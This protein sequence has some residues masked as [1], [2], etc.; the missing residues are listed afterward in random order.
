[1]NKIKQKVTYL[2]VVFIQ[3]CITATAQSTQDPIPVKVRLY[4]ETLTKDS[5]YWVADN[6]SYNNSNEPFDAYGL[7][8]ILGLAN[9]SVNGTLYAIRN[10]KKAGRLFEYKMFYHPS[11][12]RVIIEQ[13]GTD[14]TYGIG[15]LVIDADFKTD[16]IQDFTNPT[17]IGYKTRHIE[18]IKNEDRYSQSYNQKPNGDWEKSRFYIWKREKF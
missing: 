13:F 17:G 1:M 14:G 8:W 7:I 18:E 10:G 11:K 5:G 2:T 6:K 15:E 9:N 12:K 3:F 16:L 4:W